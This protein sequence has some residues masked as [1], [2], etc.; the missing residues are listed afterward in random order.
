MAKH[1]DV[2]MSRSYWEQNY[3]R[4]YEARLR[5]NFKRKLHK[6][7][8]KIFKGIAFASIAFALIAIPKAYGFYDYDS[9]IA[10]KDGIYYKT[11]DGDKFIHL[12]NGHIFDAYGYDFKNGEEIIAIFDMD[13]EDVDSDKDI[14]IN[15]VR[16]FDL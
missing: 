7:Y 1:N 4:K 16:K 2:Y 9:N 3:K 11:E 6:L 5:K 13:G 8:R 15:I 10:D 12:S 14:L